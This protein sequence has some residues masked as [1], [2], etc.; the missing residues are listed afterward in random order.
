[1]H[2]GKAPQSAAKSSCIALLRIFRAVVGT[3]MFQLSRKP[4]VGAAYDTNHMRAF[5]S[6]SSQHTGKTFS[7]DRVTTI[8]PTNSMEF[9]KLYS[10]R[11]M[12]GETAQGA[13]G[14]ELS[15]PSKTPFLQ[16]NAWNEEPLE[17]RATDICLDQ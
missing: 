13:R 9:A 7:Q 5:V 3:P 2:P 11:I 17:S 12:A 15:S 8:N 4:N 16:M 1:M 10:E 6:S 14:H